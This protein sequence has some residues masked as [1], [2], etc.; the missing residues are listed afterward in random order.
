M[1]VFWGSKVS[2][3]IIS[4]GE[5]LYFPQSTPYEDVERISANSTKRNVFAKLSIV[6]QNKTITL[7]YNYFQKGKH[8]HILI[9][10]VSSIIKF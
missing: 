5:T 8:V 7:I 10:L 9:Q 4:G 2:Q 6:E 3:I 1:V